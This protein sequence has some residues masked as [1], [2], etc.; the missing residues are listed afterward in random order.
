VTDAEADALVSQVQGQLLK[1]AAEIGCAPEVAL[2]AFEQ[3]ITLGLW[4]D[5]LSSLSAGQ[6]AAIHNLG[7][8]YRDFEKWSTTWRGWAENGQRDDGSPYSW[9]K[10]ATFADDIG[11]DAETQT[12][13]AWS[14]SPIVA[15]AESVPATVQQVVTPSLWPSWLKGG[16]AVVVALVAATLFLEVR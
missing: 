14:G 15:G 11:T 10:W 16:V 12:G 9:E 13:V 3:W 7:T 2:Y 8:D 1:G 5:S 6:Q 4:P